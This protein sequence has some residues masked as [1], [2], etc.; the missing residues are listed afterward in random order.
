MKMCNNLIGMHK[1]CMCK[2]LFGNQ[3]V[4][5]S[6]VGLKNKWHQGSHFQLQGVVFLYMFNSNFEGVA[7]MSE[8][9][10]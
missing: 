3:Q 7:L 5:T 4:F 6:G 9:K 8:F 1:P 10:N 2:D